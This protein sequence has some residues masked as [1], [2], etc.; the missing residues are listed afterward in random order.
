MRRRN[1]GRRRRSVVLACTCSAIVFFMDKRTPT[2]IGALRE[3]L[4]ARRASP[5]TVEAY[6]MWA[7]RYVRFHGRRHPRA[8][9]RAEVAAFLEHLA[10]ERPRISVSVASRPS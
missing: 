1:D 3:E 9:G 6:E 8:M 2:L 7:R 10:S 5:R 4:R